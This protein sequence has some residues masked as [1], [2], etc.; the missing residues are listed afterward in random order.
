MADENQIVSEQQEQL[1][2]QPIQK[3]V[4]IVREFIHIDTSSSS[5]LNKGGNHEPLSSKVI[6][7]D[8]LE[9]K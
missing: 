7:G 5:I 9:H 4:E 6:K 2:L 3:P 8:S 1:T